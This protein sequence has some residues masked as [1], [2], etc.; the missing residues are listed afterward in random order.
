MRRDVSRRFDEYL[1]AAVRSGE[2][3]S[4]ERL[5]KHWQPRLIAHA[6]RLTG[7]KEMAL[8]V[9]QDSWISIYRGLP[10]LKDVVVFPAWA[11]RIVT[12][13][14]ADA[15]RKKQ[16]SRRGNEALAD[17]P[18]VED[19]SSDVIEAHAD[20]RPLNR[21][22]A[23][24]PKDQQAA[25]ALHYIEGFTITEISIALEVPKGTVKTRLMHGRR[26]LRVALEGE[27]QNEQT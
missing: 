26:K 21:A 23:K 27:T 2:Q 25:I 1:A 18:F 13:R 10:S 7:D 22:M 6:Y 16:Q 15:L 19:R 9:V 4:F 3:G 14:T 11:Y 20:R 24:L 12:R 8:D 17:A 5:V